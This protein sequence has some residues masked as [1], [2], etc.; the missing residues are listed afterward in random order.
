MTVELVSGSVVHVVSPIP[1]VDIVSPQ[2]EVYVDDAP[3]VIFAVDT[4][5]LDD[6][7]AS[8]RPHEAAESGRDF[9]GWFNAMTT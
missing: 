8:A 7:I 1:G 2:T 3:H 6:H 4:A 9:A 5:A